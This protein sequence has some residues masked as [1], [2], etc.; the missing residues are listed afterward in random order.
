MKKL[1]TAAQAREADRYTCEQ[2]GI[3]SMVLMETAS[4][5]VR[6]AVLHFLQQGRAADELDRKSV[7]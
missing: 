5:A 6:D 1:L 7:V 3:P 2:I 4:M